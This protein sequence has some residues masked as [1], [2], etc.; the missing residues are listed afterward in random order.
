MATLCG[1][2]FGGRYAIESCKI[3]PIEDEVCLID[4][5]IGQAELPP[6]STMVISDSKFTRNGRGLIYGAVEIESDQPLHVASEIFGTEGD[7]FS[8]STIPKSW[9]SVEIARDWISGASII[10][11]AIPESGT[12]RL[13]LINPND[14]PIRFD[15]HSP[16]GKSGSA[17]A[18]ADGIAIVDLDSTFLGA[19][20]GAEH[21]TGTGFA[22]F[23][24]ADFPYLAA[25]VTKSSTLSPDV[26]IARPLVTA[27]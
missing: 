25:A 7:R 15:Y 5:N 27:P 20:G 26:R 24:N 18:G 16:Y 17:M 14:H 6:H 3:V 2:S 10:P 4:C 11:R 19:A 23:V 21:P 9:Q 12:F 8:G 1:E 13:Y 22:V